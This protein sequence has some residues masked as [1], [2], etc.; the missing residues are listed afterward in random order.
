MSETKSGKP[1][2]D[3]RVLLVAEGGLKNGE[4]LTP[5]AAN[6]KVDD[7]YERIGGA[8]FFRTLCTRFYRLVS[9]DEIL[10]PLFPKRDWDRQ[11]R[12]LS[13]HFV[14]LWGENDLTEA[15]R[16][17]LQ[18][19]HAHWIITRPQRLRWLELMGEAARQVGAPAEQFDEFMTIM[20]VASGEMM[21]VS[22]GAALAR[23]DAF[24]WD[25]SPIPRADRAA[26]HDED[27]P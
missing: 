14:R 7:F 16:P 4:H 2:H 5:A 23:G 27:A 1:A 10:S 8:E 12:T 9:G 22:R 21:A 11:A 17:G 25:G 13:Q 3:G 6:A 26:A 15:W 18:R 20:K 19:A 24:H